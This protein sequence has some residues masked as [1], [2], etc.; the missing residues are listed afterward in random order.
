MFVRT[1]VKRII[2][3][4][5]DIDYLIMTTITRIMLPYYRIYYDYITHTY[6]GKINSSI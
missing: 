6:C 2:T 4:I 5:F 3:D 1:V